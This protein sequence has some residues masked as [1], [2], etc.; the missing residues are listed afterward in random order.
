MT[1]RARRSRELLDMTMQSL[2]VAAGPARNDQRF[3]QK[4]GAIGST[5]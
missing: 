2:L 4:F 5:A 1:G 3:R